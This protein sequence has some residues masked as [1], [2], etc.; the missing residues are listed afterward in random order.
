MAEQKKHV[1]HVMLDTNAVFA[2]SMH[3]AFSRAAEA[4]IKESASHAD[5][6][7]RWAIPA[8]VRSERIWQ[9]RGF[10]LEHLASTR[11]MQRLFGQ[12]W[13]ENEKSIADAVAITFDQQ[14]RSM[15]TEIIE[16]DETLVDWR[17]LISAAALRLPPFSS[18]S[19]EKGF[20]DAV[21]C[22][23]FC[24]RIEKIPLHDET[25]LVVSGDD[26]LGQALRERLGEDTSVK[27]TKGISEL[28]NEI[29]FL[30]SPLD[31]ETAQALSFKAGEVLEKSRLLKDFYKQLLSDFESK[32]KAAPA[33]VEDVRIGQQ[34]LSLPVFIRKAASRL[35]FASLFTCERLGRKWVRE[36]SAIPTPPIGS[37]FGG[38]APL[39]TLS[40]SGAEPNG[41]TRKNALAELSRVLA[42]R[43]IAPP[44]QDAILTLAS[45]A[46]F[47]KS[48]HWET[49][50]LPELTF[51]FIWSAE[52]DSSGK[53]SNPRVIRVD[54]QPL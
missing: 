4:L 36:F 50:Q 20:R 42:N 3:H 6:A 13:V 35:E 21:I 27:I 17:A 44:T 26:L 8:M 18:G 37:F 28:A 16:C 33:E 30:A 38:E 5:L 10:A 45:L 43:Q 31:A 14:L 52:Y 11:N 7:L 47:Q 2:K 46:D 15:S 29:N 49:I 9:M 19:S 53:V 22:E 24:Q 54:E 32:L 39:P 51:G 41:E 23:T 1:V 48:G 40:I 25:C 34:W 12:T